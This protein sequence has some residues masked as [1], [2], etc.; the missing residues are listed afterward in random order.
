MHRRVQ[1]GGGEGVVGY[2]N[3]SRAIGVLISGRGSN[4]QALIDAIVGRRSTRAL[5]SSSRTSRR[6]ARARARARPA[7]RRWSSIIALPVATTIRSR[8]RA[9]C[10][11]R[12]LVLVCLAGFMRLIGTPLLEAFPNAILNVHPS[13][14]PAFPGWTAQAQALD[15]GVKVS[16]ATVHLVTGEL[17]G[18]P[19]VLQ[20]AVPVR[21]DD[22]VETLSAR[23]L[24]EEHRI[25][26]EA[27]DWSSTA[28]GA[29]GAG[30]S[31][32]ELADGVP[33]AGHQPVT[34]HPRPVCVA[35]EVGSQERIFE[36]HTPEHQC[37]VDHRNC[38][39]EPRAE[40]QPA[41]AARRR[42]SRVARMSHQE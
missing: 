11:T 19:I 15:H 13:L 3:R 38:D 28:A 36:E 4:L 21:D 39:A 26:P 42:S 40:R 29:R 30:A 7:S 20:A 1:R 25:Y 35:I 31:C 5:P 14:L 34:V 12:R 32:L 23:I 33:D 24:I 17:D 16:G 9:S 37:R 41:R 10:S 18:G 6:S 22:T 27:F 2:L 8:R